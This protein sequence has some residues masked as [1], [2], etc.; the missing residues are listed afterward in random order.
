MSNILI[1]GGHKLNG[2]IHVSGSKNSVTKI[3]IACI[4]T[5]DVCILENVPQILD[6]Q[7]TLEILVNLGVNVKKTQNKLV[8]QANNLCMNFIA[9]DLAKLN[10]V[11][12]MF[13][14]ALLNKFDEVSVPLPG[15]CNI[16]KRPINYHLDFLRLL[17]VDIEQDQ[18][19]FIAKCKRLRGNNICLPYPSTTTTEHILLS[20]VLAEGITVIENACQTPETIELVEVLQKMG[21][22]IE[23][24]KNGFK[25]TGVNRLSGFQHKILP[26]RNEAATLVAAALVCGGDVTIHDFPYHMTSFI[27]LLDK[28]GA[29]YRREKMSI[30]LNNDINQFSR[31]SIESGPYPNFETDW[32]PF[33]LIL[34]N[35][36]IGKGF[37]HETVF[38]NRFRFVSQVIKMGANIHL[39]EECPESITCSF[40]NK[41]IHTAEVI[42]PTKLKGR[43]L[44]VEELRG[45]AALV[46]AALAAD[47]ETKISDRDILNRGYENIVRKLKLLG[48]NIK[49]ER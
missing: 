23:Y 24:Y 13:I 32:M 1:E 33:A 28:M 35:F 17:G 16:G 9:E 19:Y 11:S 18:G 5:E 7:T 38:E 46:I 22:N 27:N 31:F 49:F 3:L 34:M 39:S 14:G 29:K 47:G 15:G 6:V 44:V 36:C 41:H 20:S 40:Y 43:N 10:R 2:H 4:L 21:A 26:D 48:A 45:G 8:I 37:A 30:H 12:F 42:G 25:I